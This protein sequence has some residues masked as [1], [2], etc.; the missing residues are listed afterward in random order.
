MTY[1]VEYFDEVLEEDILPIPVNIRLRIERAIRNR[2]MSAPEQYGERLRR[3]LI[4]LWKIRVGDYRVIYTIDDAK[5]S[6][7]IWAVGHRRLIYE[8][9]SRR[10]A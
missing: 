1:R 8:A 2:L 10:R 7:R 4:G 9:V 6:V 3:S 5:R